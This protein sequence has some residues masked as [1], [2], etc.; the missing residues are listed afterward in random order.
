MPSE[1]AA[2]VKRVEVRGPTPSPSSSFS[3]NFKGIHTNRSFTLRVRSRNELGWGPFSSPF[4][5]HMFQRG[6]T[7]HTEQCK[8]LGV[9]LITLHLRHVPARWDSTMSTYITVWT[10]RNTNPH[11]SP[12]TCSREVRQYIQYSVIFQGSF[13]SLTFHLPNFPARWDSTYSTV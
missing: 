6:E 10:F 5:F 2:E 3:Y 8:P 11:P 7:V 9:L 1:D 12:S 13:S 4:T